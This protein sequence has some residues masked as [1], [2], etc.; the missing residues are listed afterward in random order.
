MSQTSGIKALASYAACRMLLPIATLCTDSMQRRSEHTLPV[1]SIHAG[2]GQANALAVTSSLDRSCKIWGLAHGRHHCFLLAQELVQVMQSIRLHF[3]PW[4]LALLFRSLVLAISQ[5]V[6]QPPQGCA[7]INGK[8]AAALMLLKRLLL[9]VFVL[10]VFCTL[11]GSC[12][13]AQVCP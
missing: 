10:C 5:A 11:S 2:A 7:G 4:Y 8:C 13:A 9:S 1:T 12:I 6:Q 3:D